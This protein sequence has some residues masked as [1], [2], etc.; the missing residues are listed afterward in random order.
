MITIK[1][2]YTRPHQYYAVKAIRSSAYPHTLIPLE[3]TAKIIKDAPRYTICGIIDT[4]T[5]TISIGYACC[6]NDRFIKKIGQTKAYNK[7]KFKPVCRISIPEDSCAKTLFM[8]TVDTV[9]Y[10]MIKKECPDIIDEIWY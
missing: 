7:A 6:K 5:N 8:D 4:L 1:Y 2:L 9:I 10:D 3:N